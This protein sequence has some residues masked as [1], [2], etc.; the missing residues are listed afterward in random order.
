MI[1][2]GDL[3]WHGLLKQDDG[4]ALHLQASLESREFEWWWD[5]GEFLM[6]AESGTLLRVRHAAQQ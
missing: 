4:R 3:E 2:V 6:V 5:H 1:D